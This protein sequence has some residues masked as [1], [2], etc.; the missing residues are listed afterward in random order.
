MVRYQE[1]HS[2]F[3][4]EKGS[5]TQPLNLQMEYRQERIFKKRIDSNFRR[6]L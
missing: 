6:C 3:A 5:R 2:L 4:F 1:N